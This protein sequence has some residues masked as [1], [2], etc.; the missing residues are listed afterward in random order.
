MTTEVLPPQA[1]DGGM[2]RMSIL[3]HLQEL[4][5]CILKALYG[6]GVVFVA[7]LIESEKLFNVAMAPGWE[8]LRRTHIQGAN[9]V[10]LGVMEQ[11]QIFYVKVP[12]V[13][14]LFLGSP[15]ILWR[16]GRLFHRDCTRTRRNG[17]S[18]LS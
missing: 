17:P 14:S 16:C 13:A 12:V 3:E 4:R 1:E 9:F 18:H 11:F 5:A 10:A 2:A 8:A 7:C 6:Y 15:W